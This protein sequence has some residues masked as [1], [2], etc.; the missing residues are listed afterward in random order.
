VGEH[1]AK[2]ANP[3]AGEIA[4]KSPMELDLLL[5]VAITV[6][7]IIAARFISKRPHR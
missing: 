1:P 7:V 3:R 4:D 2:R 6:L 5:T